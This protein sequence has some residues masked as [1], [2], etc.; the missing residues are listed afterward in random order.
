MGK[1]DASLTLLLGNQRWSLGIRL[2]AKQ[3]WFIFLKKCLFLLFIIYLA[4]SAEMRW[5]LSAAW[6]QQLPH[7]T[8]DL[9]YPTG[10]Q[11]HVPCIGEWT[12]NQWTTQE[13]LGSVL[14][15]WSEVTYWCL[16]SSIFSINNWLLV[17]RVWVSAVKSKTSLAPI[18]LLCM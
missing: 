10:D 2:R 8:W 3:L 16:Q 9:S 5:V 14:T 7:C 18:F 12:L 17:L 11:T 6:A 1:L 4:T 13:V 15:Q